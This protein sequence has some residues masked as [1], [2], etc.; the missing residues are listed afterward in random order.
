MPPYTLILRLPLS[1]S[2]SGSGSGSRL[3]ISGSTEQKVREFGAAVTVA[4]DEDGTESEQVAEDGLPKGLKMM[5][6]KS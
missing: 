5:E 4:V 3:I 2:G 1:K 6:H